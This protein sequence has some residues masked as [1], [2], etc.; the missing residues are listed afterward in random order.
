TELTLTRAL[1]RARVRVR[2]LAADREALAV[3][4]TTVAAEIHQALDVHRDF[5]AQVAFDLDAERLEDVADGAHV[6]L[7]EIVAALVGRDLG[8]LEHS[9][10]R[11]L[12]N[13]VDVRERDLDALVARKVDAGDASHLTLPLLMLGVLADDAHHTLAAHHLALRTD[14]FDRSLDFH[15]KNPSA[16]RTVPYT[17]RFPISQAKSSQSAQNNRPLL[18]YRNRMLEVSGKLAILGDRRPAVG[19]HLDF[20]RPGVDHRLDGQHQARFQ[21]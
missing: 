9:R 17:F 7:V 6:V 4:Q 14:L 3:A 2:A 15:W 11:S 20:M 16:K 1:A 19:E 18:G 8:L 10:R 21:T 5:A 12:A 13:A